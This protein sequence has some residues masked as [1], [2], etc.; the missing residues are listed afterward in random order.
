MKNSYRDLN[1]DQIE[2]I[3]SDATNLNYWISFPVEVYITVK[4]VLYKDYLYFGT[5]DYKRSFIKP[6][7]RNKIIN[8]IKRQLLSPG[9]I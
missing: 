6:M 1:L 5:T 4:S 7:C 8:I 9:Q 3:R 2:F